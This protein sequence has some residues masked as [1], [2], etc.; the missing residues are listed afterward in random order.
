MKVLQII[1]QPKINTGGAMQMCLLANYLYDNNVDVIVVFHKNINY[2]L[3][4]YYNFLNKNIKIRFFDLPKFSLS[5]RSINSILDLRNFIKKEN[6]DIIHIHKSRAFTLTYIA[7][8]G[9][10][11]PLVVNRGVI[12]PLDFFNSLKY[13]SRKV[14]KIIA[15]SEAVKKSIVES[16]N[17]NPEKIEVVYG[18]IDLKR[19]DFSI[20]S[21]FKKEFGISDDEFIFGYVG[22]DLKRKGLEYLLSAFN[23]LENKYNNI[24]LVLVG[25][26]EN[27]KVVLEYEEL[28]KNRKVICTG[29][30]IDIP[31]IMK[32]FDAFVFA[33]ISDE[34]LTGVIR[35]AA[36]MKIPVITT[37]VAGN[38]EFIQNEKNGIVVPK[39]DV[40]SLVAAMEKIYLNYDYYKNLAENAYKFVME[41]M[42]ND[43]RGEKILKIYYDV[44]SS[45]G[46]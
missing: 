5:K 16:A 19:F 27:S 13:K 15:V 31:R 12:I 33:G 22:N 8:L 2:S 30:R 9:V 35:E 46:V 42:N 6:F 20:E 38:E 4:Y 17:V 18:S 39:K 40:K 3:D 43:V 45:K 41:N 21:N 23:I 24:T 32:S 10:D 26:S 34:G 36:A 7:T 11:I 28:L 29:Y 1:A 25:V 37:D 44:I 14:K